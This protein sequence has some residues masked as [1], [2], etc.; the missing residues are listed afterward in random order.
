MCHAKPDLEAAR[1]GRL[2]AEEDQVERAGG[3]LV[4]PHRIHDGSRRRLGIPLVAVR[5]EVDCPCDADRHRIAELLLGVGRAEREHDRVAAVVLPE[6]HCLLDA[7]LLVR[8]DREAEV[9][10]LDRLL[11]LGEDDPAARHGY[12][13]DAHESLHDRILAFSGSNGAAAPATATVTGK[14]SFMYSTASVPEPSTAC[15]GGR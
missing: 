6:P 1:V 12:A 7:A 10:R 4:G 5:D 14:R 11:V 2:V 13:L 8:A 15:S 9:L 3:G